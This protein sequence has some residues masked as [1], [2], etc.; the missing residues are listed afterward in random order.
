LAV[1]DDIQ[2]SPGT[3]LLEVDSGDGA[4][5]QL[6]EQQEQMITVAS[7]VVTSADEATTPAQAQEQGQDQQQVQILE[8]QDES[9]DA[10]VSAAECANFW[11]GEF[12]GKKD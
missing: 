12:F 8:S 7:L 4:M 1:V 2:S 9:S 5:T 10:N 11:Y 3:P 6:Q